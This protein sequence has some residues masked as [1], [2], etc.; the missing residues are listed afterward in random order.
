MA[1]SVNSDREK[2]EEVC[3]FTQHVWEEGYYGWTCRVCGQLIPYGCEP[4]APQEDDWDETWDE[5]EE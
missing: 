5:W 2:A 3:A 4:W 1:S